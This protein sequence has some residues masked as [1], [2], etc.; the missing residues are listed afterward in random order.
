LARNIAISVAYVG[1]RGVH[2]WQQLEGN[3][4]IPTAVANGVQYW[5]NSVPFCQIGI[6]PTC[7]INPNFGAVN[8][9]NTVGVS[10]YDSL[11]VVGSKRLSG[12]L[13]ARGA[14]NYGH[15]LNT[16]IG[17][18]ISS[19]CAGAPGMDA[20]VSSITRAYDY[21]PS[22]FD[23]RH[24]LRMSL[25][26]HF[27][28]LVSNGLLSKLVNG[29]WMGNI[30]AL[31]T[32]YPFTPILATNR[33]NSRNLST[34]PDRVDINT[35]AIAQGTLLTN[36]EGGAYVAATNFIPYNPHT[37]ITG[38][39][40]QW[41]N[42]N[43]FHMQPMVP[44]PNNAGLTCGTLGDAARGILRGPNLGEWDFSIVKD[45]AVPLFGKQGSIQFRTEI[46]NILNHTN[47]GM[48][49]SATVFNGATSVL[50]EY[51]QAPLA[52]VGQITTTATTSRQIQFA[53]KLIF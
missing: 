3:P 18:L 8:T 15:S 34:L 21:G 43:M 11:Q 4:T 50:G 10:H 39:P 14:Y 22:C 38:N 20:G 19:D 13:E 36:A 46:F 25:L 17:Q 12:G 41:F 23:V 42:P 27:P 51:E 7:R 32:G 53:L 28:N 6:I 40:N 37:V 31:Q 49:A 30:V 24:S 1:S 45:T 16:P 44:C 9:N 33:S 48:P 35:Q 29:W 26:Y 52:G 2:L 5:S 47:L